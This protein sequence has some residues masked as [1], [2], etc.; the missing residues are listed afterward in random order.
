MDQYLHVT[1]ISLEDSKLC[2]DIVWNLLKD[3]NCVY[4]DARYCML[5]TTFSLIAMT[6]LHLLCH[7]LIKMMLKSCC[8][9]VLQGGYVFVFCWLV[10]LS[11]G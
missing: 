2:A 8:Y 10:G 1:S 5:M 4:R 6:G 7:F 9:C 11:A 3:D